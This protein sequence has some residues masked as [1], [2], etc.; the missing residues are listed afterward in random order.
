[1]CGDP[2][3]GRRRGRRATALVAAGES[4][5]GARAGDPEARRYTGASES[6]IDWGFIVGLGVPF[7]WLKQRLMHK[8][9][10]LV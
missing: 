9:E 2:R 6:R 8:R 5:E 4:S 3:G 1:M 7:V 10:P